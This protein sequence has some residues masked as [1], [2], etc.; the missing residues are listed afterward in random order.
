MSAQRVDL[1]IVIVNWNTK[2]MLRDCL[3]SVFS[4]THSLLPEVMVVDNA[5]SDGSP[6]MVRMQFPQVHL[7]E[8]QE[9][10]GFAAANN[11]AFSFCSAN[12]IL[13]LN[14][15]TRILGD[16]IEV[17]VKFM[18][19]HPE[20]G[21]VGP[22]IVHPRMR[23]RVLSSG[24]Q[25]TLRR[26]FNHYFWLS[27]LFP[28]LS[29]FQGINLLSGVHDDRIRSVEW[30]S[31]TCL[32]VRR[33][34]IE[35]VGPLSDRWFMYSEDWEWCQRMLDGG[36][37]LYHVPQAVVEHHFGAAAAQNEVVS[38]MWVRSL[39]SY[40]IS[41]E[42]PS[43]RQ[44]AMFDAILVAGLTLRAGVYFLC[45]LVDRQRGALWRSEARKFAAYAQASVK[46]ARGL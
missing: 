42:E 4:Q 18:K 22:K 15:D 20:A 41:R 6:A 24:Y 29:A 12:Y 11:Q 38:T 28:R 13:L 10:R 39:R 34:V 40:F 36:W 27:S 23:L 2:E 3:R 33:S 30:I 16:A 35:Q 8:N 43:R 32:L 31:G 7:H 25:P 19:E 26:L 21:A 45:G 44:R 17:L 14:P 9:N 37:R 46:A 5:S 1:S